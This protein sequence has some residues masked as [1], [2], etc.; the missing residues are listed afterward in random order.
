MGGEKG[1]WERDKE[2][3]D[4]EEEEVASSMLVKKPISAAHPTRTQIFFSM[5][6]V[7]LAKK[8]TVQHTAWRTRDI[9]FS[10]PLL[11]NMYNFSLDIKTLDPPDPPVKPQDSRRVLTFAFLP[12]ATHAAAAT[13]APATAS[14]PAAAAA[15][16]RDP[17]AGA[18]DPA[19]AA[20]CGRAG[21]GSGRLRILQTQ[22]ARVRPQ[23]Q[24]PGR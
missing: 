22:A 3:R 4:G 1:G 15:A 24:Q 5:S 10:F 8:L 23:Q 21:A 7:N 17:A 18:R 2:D 6:Q 19:A 13:P 9:L 12:A 16:P 11:S 14:H 20:R